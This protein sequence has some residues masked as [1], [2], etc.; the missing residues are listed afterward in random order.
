MMMTIK[1]AH[2][3]APANITAITTTRHGGVSQ[4]PYDSNNL[5]LHVA[6]NEEHVLANRQR[7]RAGLHLPAEPIWL[8]QTHSTHCI[9]AEEDNHRHADAA[10]T[11]SYLHPLAILT[12][13][14]LPI[15]LCNKQGTE[16]AAVHAGWR[17]LFNGIVENTLSKMHS[18]STD[19]I[20]WV[21]PA[22]SQK[23]YEVG[24]DVYDSFIQKHPDSVIAFQP[25][26]PTKWLANLA[27]IA[28]LIMLNQGIK[29][30]YQSNLCTFTTKDEFYSYRKSAQTGRIA[31]LIWFN[32]PTLQQRIYE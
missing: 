13:D 8:E 17:G 32:T 6:D 4:F 23:H 30:V 3:P 11:R 2:W 15:V 21:G 29:A 12:A 24:K 27:L 1:Q 18:K 16:I 22:I 5:A 25:T 7:L 20:A 9:I 10:I 28:E 31:T 26:G 14:C 19:I